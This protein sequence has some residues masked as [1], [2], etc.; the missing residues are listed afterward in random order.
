[1]NPATPNSFNPVDAFILQKL[2]EKD[3]TPSPGLADTQEGR[4]TL[5]RAT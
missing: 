3:M 4:M 2:E 1:V 5:R